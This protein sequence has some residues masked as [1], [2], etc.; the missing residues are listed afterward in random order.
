MGTPQCFFGHPLKGDNFLNFLIAFLEIKTLNPLYMYTARLFHYY[1]LE[2]SRCY[3]MGV[4]PFLSFLFY[5]GRKSLLA[6]N[7]DSDQTPHD[8]WSGSASYKANMYLPKASNG[9]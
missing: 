1:I 9:R 5:F 7:V 8:V 3:F 2:E 6:N 4:R